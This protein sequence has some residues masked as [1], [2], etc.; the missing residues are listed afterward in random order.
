MHFS[1]A[2]YMYIAATPSIHAT[3]SSLVKS[4]YPVQLLSQRDCSEHSNFQ[5]FAGREGV[6]GGG[7]CPGEKSPYFK[8][9]GVGISDK[10]TSFAGKAFTEDVVTKISSLCIWVSMYMTVQVYVDFMSVVSC[11]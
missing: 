1:I 9:P 10:V 7:E 6:L 8:A 3:L 2:S 5:K 11:R 4:L